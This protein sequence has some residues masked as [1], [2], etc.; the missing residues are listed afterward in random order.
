MPFLF[1]LIFFIEF[2]IYYFGGITHKFFYRTKIFEYYRILG[3]FMS[4]YEYLK[5]KKMYM[6]LVYTKYDPD[7]LPKIQQIFDNKIIPRLHETEGCL[8]VCLI[9]S[10]LQQDEGISMTLWDSQAHADAYERSGLYFEFLE[11]LRQFQG[12]VTPLFAQE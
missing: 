3:A 10:E 5:E 12:Q 7:Y 8:F 11:E 4:T 6:R 9:K 1:F 2:C